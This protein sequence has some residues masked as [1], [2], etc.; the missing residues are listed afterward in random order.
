MLTVL[1]KKTGVQGKNVVLGAVWMDG[2]WMEQLHHFALL[3]R[4]KTPL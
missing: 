1:K 4:R 2:T 3:K